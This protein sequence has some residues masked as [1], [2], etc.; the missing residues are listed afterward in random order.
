MTDQKKENILVYF[1]NNL[2]TEI[3]KEFLLNFKDEENIKKKDGSKKYIDLIQK[4]K[5]KEINFLEIH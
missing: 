3:L 5:D 1:N 2:E 4:I